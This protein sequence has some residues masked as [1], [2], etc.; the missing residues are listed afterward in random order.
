M[1]VEV[2]TPQDRPMVSVVIPH[3]RALSD[4]GQCLDALGRQTYP[5]DR[6]EIIVADNN[7]PEG[8]A[9]VAAAIAG[10]AQL[11]VVVEKGAGPARNGGAALARGEV[12]AFTDSDCVPQPDWLTEGVRALSGHDVVGG[13]MKVLV[14]DP[15][16]MT[17]AEAFETVFAFD[18]ESYVAHKGFT[19]S[20]NLLCRRALFEKVGGFLSAGYAEDVEWCNRALA[21]GFTL[22]YAP[23]S[24]VGHPA[25]RTWEDLLKKW[26]RTN[27]DNYGVISR[28]RGGKTYWFLRT[29][30]IPFSAVAHSPKVFQSSKL[31]SF[32]QKLSALSV[33]YRLRMWR[34]G[35]SFRLLLVRRDA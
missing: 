6:V 32:G 1:S 27:S 29:F 15:A 22:G 30:L 10:R 2:S 17:P 20:A 31:Y 11:V 34:F 7:S 23:A 25:R 35:D 16:R 14:D 8:E 19:V 26:R 3:Y 21:S 33:L 4:L 9:A 13:R 5:A 18:N 28:R 12:L 24:I